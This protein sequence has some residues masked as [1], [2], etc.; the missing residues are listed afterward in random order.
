MEYFSTAHTY[1]VQ[2]RPAFVNKV[3]FCFGLAVLIAALGVQGGL[4]LAA[5]YPALFLS[6]LVFWG[7]LIVELVL[8]FTIHLWQEKTPFNYIAF[9]LFAAISGFTLT[10]LLLGA[11]SVAGVGIIFKALI[12]T[13]CTFASAAIFGAV[14]KKDL[15]SISSILMVALVGMIIGGIVNMFLGSNTIEII[16]SSLGIIVFTAF[17]AYDIQNIKERY[18]D[19][20]YMVAAIGLFLDFINLFVSILRLLLAMNRD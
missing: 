1:S 9:V 12:A 10:P 4:S 6:P 2:S 5:N 18:P 7:A 8:V 3:F 20:M 14:T 15:S 17:T 19:N 16:L 13:T 11:I